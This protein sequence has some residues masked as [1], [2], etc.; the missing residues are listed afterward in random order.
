M[1][2]LEVDHPRSSDCQLDVAGQQQ[3]GPD[4]LVLLLLHHSPPSQQ[5]QTLQTPD[6]RGKHGLVVD[7]V[8]DVDVVSLSGP[9]PQQ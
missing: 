3:Q 5:P 1:R 2:S 9:S 7:F 8:V 4:L 6:L